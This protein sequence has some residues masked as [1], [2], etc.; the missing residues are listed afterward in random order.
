MISRI[1][2]EHLIIDPEIQKLCARP[3]YKHPHG[4]PKFGK[5]PTCPPNQLLLNEVFDFNQELFVIYTEF[6]VGNIAERVRQKHPDWTPRQWYNLRYWQPMA[7]QF[8]AQEEQRAIYE[9][10]IE[11]DRDPEAHGVNITEL[12]KTKGIVLDWAWPPKHDLQ[13][14]RYRNNITFRIS[15][16][17]HKLGN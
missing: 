16:G 7:R 4:C 3:Y 12:M 17:G 9:F 11:I 5:C 1:N 14:E 6:G 13:K 8:Q 10:G 15:L 2:P